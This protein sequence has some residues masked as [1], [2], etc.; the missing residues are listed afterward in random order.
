MGLRASR[1]P[2][3]LPAPDPG[4]PPQPRR[5]LW[6]S[7]ISSVP[8]PPGMGSAEPG[9]VVG[10]LGWGGLLLGTRRGSSAWPAW[11]AVRMGQGSP[12]VQGCSRLPPH[13]PPRP[14]QPLLLI[15]GERGPPA[16]PG[17]E[18]KAAPVIR[19]LDSRCAACG[20]VTGGRPAPVE[21]VPGSRPENSPSWGGWGRGR[22]SAGSRCGEEG[23]AVPALGPGPSVLGNPPP[24]QPQLR[25]GLA[26]CRWRLAS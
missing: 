1:R 9:A 22:Q 21:D 23:S 26:A 14:A 24:R 2:S 3:S 5:G 12:H 7:R 25:A 10:Q 17:P 13:L 11:P 18:H 19:A 16:Q 15:P 20:R 6:A 4:S 8:G